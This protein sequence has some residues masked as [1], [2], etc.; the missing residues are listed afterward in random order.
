MLGIEPRASYIVAEHS[1]FELRA[2]NRLGIVFYGRAKNHT[3]PPPQKKINLLSFDK[4]LWCSR[5]A[6]ESPVCGDLL[7]ACTVQSKDQQTPQLYKTRLFIWN[8][9]A[10]SGKGW[11]I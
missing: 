4:E 3:T 5:T 8:S 1:T 6:S 10:R 2:T 11:R 9:K 7:R